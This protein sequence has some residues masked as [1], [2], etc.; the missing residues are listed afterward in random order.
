M[1][2]ALAGSSGGLS[3]HDVEALPSIRSPAHV[4]FAS[5][6]PGCWQRLNRHRVILILGAAYA[7]AF[8]EEMRMEV[9]I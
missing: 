9:Q 7:G 5:P 2:M 1:M 8:G 6:T 4:G 3:T